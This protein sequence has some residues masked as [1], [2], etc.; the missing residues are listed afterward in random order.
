MLDVDNDTAG[1]YLRRLA[2]NGRTRK[3]E[4]GIAIRSVRL[5]E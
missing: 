4:R 1:T 3:T 2:E 5:S